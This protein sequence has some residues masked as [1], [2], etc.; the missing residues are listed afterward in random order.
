MQKCGNNLLTGCTAGGVHLNALC[1][2]PARNCHERRA[3]LQLIDARCGPSPHAELPHGLVH[4]LN[5]LIRA[6]AF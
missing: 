6:L 3:A 1:D 2:A 4:A 5:N